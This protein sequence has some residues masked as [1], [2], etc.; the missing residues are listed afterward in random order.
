[1][2]APVDEDDSHSL[3]VNLLN[4]KFGSDVKSLRQLKELYEY[5]KHEM[6]TLEKQL[7]LA[8]SEVPTEV[9]TALRNAKTTQR[10]VQNLHER[11]QTLRHE[12][13]D[14]VRAHQS[15][16]DHASK[17]TNQI[18][19]L[20]M[21]NQYLSMVAKVENISSE[22][23][24]ALLTDNFSSAVDGFSHMTSI[25]GQMQDTK[26]RHLL[27]FTQDTVI[28]WFKILK[29]KIASEFES[30]LKLV[31]W[32]LIATSIKSPP[33]QTAEVKVKME[34]LFMQL[35][36]LQL[37]ERLYAEVTSSN[38]TIQSQT[39]NVKPLLL[40][41]DLMVRP[42]KKRF[43]YHFYGNKQ[44]NSLGKPEWY[45]SQVLSWIRD[46]STFLD[47]RI[48][49][50]LRKAGQEFVDAKIEFMRGLVIVVME[51]VASDLS[52]V[53]EDEAFF[54]HLID[55]TIFFDRELHG[56]FGY[57]KGMPSCM[58]VLTID[59]V[60]EK[61]LITENKF[62]GE[63]VDVMLSSPSA[64]LSQYKDITD[65][66]DLKVPECGEGFITLMSTITDRY[67]YLPSPTHRLKFLQLQ[68]ELLE[69]FRIRLVQVMKEVTLNPLGDMFCAILNAVHFVTEVLKDW[70]N[71]VFFLQLQY[72][73]VTDGQDYTRSMNRS[74]L[75]LQDSSITSE[76]EIPSEL[77][78]AVESTVFDEVID[79]YSKLEEEMLKNLINHVFM[80]VQ[81]RSQQYRKDRWMTLPFNKELA[82]QGLSNSAC[83]M[84]LVLKDHLCTIQEAL[85]KPLFTL[86]WQRLAEK[87][88][89]FILNE[90]VLQ[91]R[92]N[93]GGA[94]QI[95]FDMTRNLFPLFGEYTH[96]PE[97]Y[98]REVKEACILLTLK[99]GSAIL[100]KDVISD[101]SGAAKHSTESETALQD[102][103]IYTL[104]PQTALNV[105][106]S[107]TN[108]A[109]G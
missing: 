37:P 104:K 19:H 23:Q 17:L 77:C 26:C 51:K 33:L 40:P 60:F 1:M 53:M 102:V 55:E 30:V 68:L 24:T 28:F 63:K 107:R 100:L 22:I 39:I 7:S 87:L 106:N 61:W 16:V 5:T 41:L 78:C 12:V 76:T 32:P 99:V 27:K 62:A 81:A 58:D 20:Q 65:V 96:K 56:S 64:W 57:P 101:K 69:D 75:E 42:L 90:V 79:L 11:S 72:Y 48:Q 108:L 10:S 2:A 52:L 21:Y 13:L 97:S 74:D 18:Q 35:L 92:F 45:F 83:E 38:L 25:Y 4:V 73:N 43:R 93:D 46:H 105:I 103:G 94:L 67:K 89:T 44:T 82:G 3:A 6:S 98:F 95:Q 71:L 49:P 80:D 31:G 8:S 50:L 15:L 59:E 109:V 86:V 9:D 29:D 88:S 47:E 54:S 34:T 14:H 36:H 66:D 85:S 84:L 70:S 91:N